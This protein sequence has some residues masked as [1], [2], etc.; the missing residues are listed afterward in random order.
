MNFS[1][2]NSMGSTISILVGLPFLL[3]AMV[4]FVMALRGRR[5]AAV[6]RQWPSTNGRVISSDIEMR[7]SSGS[8]HSGYSP[9]PVVVYEYEVA[10]KRFMNNKIGSGTQVGGSLIAQPT[11]NRYPVG[12]KVPVYYNPENPIDSVLEPGKSTSSTILLWVSV[13]IIVILAVTFAFTFGLTN[14]ISQLIPQVSR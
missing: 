4:L 6:T 8:N 13:L 2:M 12:M 11:V 3:V 5:K 1:F 9:Y 7:Y 10:G 14:Q